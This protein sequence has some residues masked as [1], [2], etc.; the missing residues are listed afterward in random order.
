VG[1]YPIGKPV[2]AFVESNPHAGLFALAWV[3]TKFTE[4]VRLLVTIMIVPR[5]ARYLGR[6]PPKIVPPKP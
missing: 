4:P 6:V 5:I 2:V 1:G 3:T